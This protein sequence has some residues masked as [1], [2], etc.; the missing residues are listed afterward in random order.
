MGLSIAIIYP[1]YDFV[2]E[3]LNLP[4]G[5]IVTQLRSL[6]DIICGV[7]PCLAY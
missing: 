5:L 2:G 4:S 7:F 6:A 3:Q 1:V